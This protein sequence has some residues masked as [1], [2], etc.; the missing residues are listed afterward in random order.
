MD[1]SAYNV[2]VTSGTAVVA[3]FVLS[4]PLGGNCTTG[5]QTNLITDYDGSRGCSPAKKNL[6]RLTPLLAFDGLSSP[7]GANRMRTRTFLAAPA[8]SR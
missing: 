5:Y 7:R 3:W 4:N 2:T 6:R 1:L 8:T